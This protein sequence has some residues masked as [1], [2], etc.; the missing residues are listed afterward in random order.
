MGP[1]RL[2]N[3]NRYQAAGTAGQ[4][5]VKSAQHA[6]ALQTLASK[7][8]KRKV[9]HNVRY[10]SSR[11]PRRYRYYATNAVA[12][13]RAVGASPWQYSSLAQALSSR[14]HCHFLTAWLRASDNKPSWMGCP[15]KS[16]CA[17]S[18]CGRAQCGAPTPPHHNRAPRKNC[19][20]PCASSLRRTTAK[21][22]RA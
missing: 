19:S 13:L 7:A 14:A 22:P 3:T 1:L 20:T 8:A 16:A 2:T 15:K 17:A 9:R 11:R 10:S 18:F 6:S 21:C 4:Q 5:Q 12:S